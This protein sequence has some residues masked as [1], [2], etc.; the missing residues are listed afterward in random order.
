MLAQRG[1]SIPSVN[2]SVSSL[3]SLL[4][5]K[6]KLLSLAFCSLPR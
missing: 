5:D 4:N 2:T 3:V 1:E 6:S